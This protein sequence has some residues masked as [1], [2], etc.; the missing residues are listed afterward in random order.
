M[1]VSCI[2]QVFS[3]CL[4]KWRATSKMFPASHHNSVYC[5]TESRALAENTLAM[6]GYVV[7]TSSRRTHL[8]LGG[9]P[10]VTLT[11]RTVSILGGGGI[12][13]REVTLVLL[14]STALSGFWLAF[15]PMKS[16]VN[17][18]LLSP[19]LSDTSW[20]HYNVAFPV[21]WLRMQSYVSNLLIFV[22]LF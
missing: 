9:F 6:G 4:W 22:F 11:I 13:R 7:Q 17:I 12:P 20:W 19:V 21:Q 18:L 8:F 15:L 2:Q 5:L 10:M 1:S 16:C 14:S 3:K